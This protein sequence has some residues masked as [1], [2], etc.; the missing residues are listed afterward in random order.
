MTLGRQ[1]F[2]ITCFRRKTIGGYPDYW[3][4]TIK[5]PGVSFYRGGLKFSTKES[6]DRE[7]W[8]RVKAA[9]PT[10]WEVTDHVAVR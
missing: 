6:E 9:T 10:G 7:H 2:Q 3:R 5:F 8:E 4:I 1:Q